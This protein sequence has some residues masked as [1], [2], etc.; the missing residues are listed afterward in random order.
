MT[1]KTKRMQLDEI[2]TAN[3]KLTGRELSNALNDYFINVASPNFVP[4][5][6]VNAFPGFATPLPNS[7]VLAPTTPKEIATLILSLK[8]DVSAGY[9]DIKVIPL[10]H[11]CDVICDVLSH[12]VNLM[13]STG[14]FPDKLK[15]ARVVPIHKGGDIN[16]LSNYRPISVL[17]VLSKI[18]ESVINSRLTDFLH[19][20]NVIADSQYGFTKNKSTEQALLVVK[21]KIID[22]IESKKFT[23]GL[24]LD[25]R[26]AFDCVNHETLLKKLCNYGVRGIAL[27]LLQSYLCNRSQYVRTNNISSDTQVVKHGVPQGSILGP[28]LFITYINDLADIPNSPDLV[29]YADDTNLFFASRSLNALQNMVNAYLIHLRD[30]LHTNKLSLN[31]N[32][33]KYIIFRPINTVGT[34]SIQIYYDNI[35]IDQVTSQKFLGVWFNEN[36]SWSVHTSK[37]ASELSKIVGLFFRISNLLP[38]WLKM[39]MYNALFLSKLSYCN[40]VWGTTTSSNYR[41]LLV[42]QKRVLRVIEGYYGA[43]QHLRT[44]PL[45]VKHCMLKANEVYHLRL[46]QY[47]HRNRLYSVPDSNISY[48]LRVVKLRLPRTRTNYGKQKLSFQVPNVMN[49]FTF[50]DEFSLSRRVFKKKTK[51]H[52]IKGEIVI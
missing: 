33:T 36:L 51:Q 35:R 4:Q 19:K 12:I 38:V 42:L 20:Y 29:M 5:T 50:V 28:L 37:L 41:K 25:F 22:N 18:F 30:W 7:V 43:P 47:I 16:E 45:F 8:N 48:N 32:K 26:K 15:L 27:N 39:S 21:D 3:G 10:K 9:D 40:L 31:I 17:P 11:V 13:L 52:L 1:N 44:Q 46:L 24:F 23:L 2:I 49:K 6:S 14:V 34:N